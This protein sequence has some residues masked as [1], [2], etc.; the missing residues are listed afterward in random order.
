[1]AV[2]QGTV[3]KVACPLSFRLERKNVSDIQQQNSRLQG[4]E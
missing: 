2:Q 1:M 4:D 3:A